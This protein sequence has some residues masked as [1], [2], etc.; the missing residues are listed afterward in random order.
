MLYFK[1]YS[2]AYGETEV[3]RTKTSLTAKW[4]RVQDMHTGSKYSLNAASGM[5]VP[6]TSNIRYKHILDTC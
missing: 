1:E 4:L 5:Q 6:V 3:A 2:S